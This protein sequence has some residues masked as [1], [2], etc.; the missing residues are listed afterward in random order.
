MKTDNP[1]IT[2]RVIADSLNR[3]GN[4]LTS[5]VITLPRIVLAEFNTIV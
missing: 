2:A 1:N 3:S 4:R 5:L